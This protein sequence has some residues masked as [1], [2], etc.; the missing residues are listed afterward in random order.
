[1]KTRFALRA[2]L[3]TMALSGPFL[4]GIAIAVLLLLNQR[5]MLTDT[6]IQLRKEAE[7]TLA[8]TA[9]GVYNMV[10]TQD[11]LLRLKLTGDLAVAKNLVTA[12]GGISLAQET[13]PWEA[14]DQI[15]KKATSIALPQMMLGSTWL[16]QNTTSPHHRPPSTKCRK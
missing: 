3:V 12:A 13:V 9:R 1:M 10:S 15:A 14:V 8:V 2:R 6:E 16:G 5:S 7:A 11:Q 4:L